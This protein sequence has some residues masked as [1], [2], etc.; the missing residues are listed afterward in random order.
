MNST[1]FIGT[2]TELTW[3]NAD[4]TRMKESASLLKITLNVYVLVVGGK[5]TEHKENSTEFSLYLPAI[6]LQIFLVDFY[7]AFFF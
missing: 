7:D 5:D 2:C 6:E 1:E 3:N 4:L